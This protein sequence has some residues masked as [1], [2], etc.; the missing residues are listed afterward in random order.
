[1]CCVWLWLCLVLMLCVDVYVAGHKVKHDTAWD[2]VAKA[3]NKECNST[4]T[5]MQTWNQY[6]QIMKEWKVRVEGD[7]SVLMYAC[8]CAHVCV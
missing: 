1:M 6:K 3:I 2:E 7:V 4:Y 8:V 5:G